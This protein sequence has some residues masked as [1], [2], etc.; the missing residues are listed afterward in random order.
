MGVA[1]VARGRVT[2]GNASR[3]PLPTDPGGLVFNKIARDGVCVVT[4]PANPM[5]NISQ[6]IVQAIFSGQIRNWSEVPGSRVNGPISLQVRN[7]ASGTQDAFQSIFMGP[8]LRVTP[9]STPHDSNGLVQ[10]GVNSDPNAIGYVSLGIVSGVH[11]VPYNGV[12]CDLR[13]AKSG[14]YGGT[15]NFWMVTRGA[16]SGET[17]KFIKWAQ[18]SS[19]ASKIVATEWV[20]LR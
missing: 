18:K 10:Q 11:S 4:N 6:E 5:G 8:D 2:I 13:N 14:Q 1:D 9:N 20:P 19:Q 15:R 12:S 3:D 16:S 7:P 17:A